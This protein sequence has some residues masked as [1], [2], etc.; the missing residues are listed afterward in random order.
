[1]VKKY[2]VVG[3]YADNQQPWITFV[4]AASPKIAAR[5][6]IRQLY[7]NGSCGA[8]LEDI[9]VVEVLAGHNQGLL[10]NQKVSSLDTL[11]RKVI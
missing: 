6:G 3:F 4:E 11:K 7:D 1:M 10:G 8:A 9:F 2:T 5:K